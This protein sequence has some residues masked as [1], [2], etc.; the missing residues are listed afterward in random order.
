[1]KRA[2]P[3]H[4][5]R[6]GTRIA[7]RGRKSAL[8]RHAETSSAEWGISTSGFL[9]ELVR[10]HMVAGQKD[11]IIDVALDLVKARGGQQKPQAA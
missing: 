6:A 1:M 5:R 2:P 3:A 9:A 4:C 7:N 8:M 11:A 10:R